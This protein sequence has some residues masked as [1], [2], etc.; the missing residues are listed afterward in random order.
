MVDSKKKELEDDLGKVADIAK[1]C[2]KPVMDFLTM[3]L[4]Y[5]VTYSKKAHAFYL[6]LPH[7]YI[8]LITGVVFCFMGGFYPALFAAIEAARFGGIEIVKNSL[9]DLADEALKII[10]ES[11]KDDKLD[12]DGDGVAD[13]KQIDVDDYIIRKGD[14]VLRKMNPEK[15]NHAIGAMY[16]VW[17]SVLAVLAVQFARVATMSATITEFVQKP[18]D[19]YVIPVLE[20]AAPKEYRKWVPVTISWMV[21]L[22]AMSLAWYIQTVISAVGSAMRGGLMI[23]R[24]LMKLAYNNGWKFVPQDDTETNIDE[25]ASYVL[26]AF[27]FWFQF[28][29]NFAVPFPFNVLLFPFE[30]AE[31][32]IKYKVADSS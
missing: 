7:D 17:L 18:L 27:G 1:K 2:A 3:I 28:Q 29:L 26:A 10:E 9:S 16:K 14:L 25:Y 30:L 24:S 4:P 6:K 5:V 32:M 31:N 11:K 20:P 21:K 23:S 19:R 13:V 12:K 15:V 8:E 22:S